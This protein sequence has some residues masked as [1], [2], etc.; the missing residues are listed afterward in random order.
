MPNAITGKV[1]NETLK[2]SQQRENYAETQ[3]EAKE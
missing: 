1:Y 3:K 2:I